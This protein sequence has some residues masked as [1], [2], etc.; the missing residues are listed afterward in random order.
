V[1]KDD[2]R[3]L[4]VALDGPGSSGKSTVGAEAAAQVGYRFCDTG[5][6][7]RA[8]A[9]LA[10]DRGVAPG[11]VVGVVPLAAEVELIAD[12]RGRLCRVQVGGRDVT[13]KVGR[14]RVDR[15]V[16][17]YAQMPELRSALVPR[18]RAIAAGGGIIMAGRDIGT[19]ILPDADVK[20]YLR[21]SA[22]ER[23]RRRAVQRHLDPAGPEAKRILDE[24]RRRDGID[25]GRATAP[26]R[27]AADALVIDTDGKTYE[28]TVAALVRAIHE[29][30]GRNAKAGAGGRGV[31]LLPRFCGGA[32]RVVAAGLTRVKVEGI[33]KIPLTGPLLIICNHVSS[34]D[35]LLLMGYI[36]PKMGRPMC[37]LGKAEALRWPVFGWAMRANGIFGV[38]RGAGD[39]EAF[40]AATG[41]LDRGE[42]LAIFPEGTRSPTGELQAAKEGAT[43]LAL[44]S[45]AR[46]CPIAVIGSQRFW[47]KGKLLPH[48]GHKMQVRVGDPFTLTMPAGADRKEALRRA[49]TELM[50]HIAE[51]LPP[52]QRGVYADAVQAEGEPRVV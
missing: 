38:R 37:W 9:W 40:R 42:V 29:T 7:Y 25:S 17:D 34:A 19:V 30:R 44:R 36:A 12:D 46:I 2:I 39:L 14:A 48:P 20:V 5:L 33:E 16:S 10:M 24:L 47:R 27:T 11:D 23:A 6:L 26:L 32:V 3:P 21:A 43:V 31:R 51:L 1:T 4:V 13:T 8:V 35:G 49:T 28:E 15:A 52:D 18:Q 22:E 41:V 45:G 50:R